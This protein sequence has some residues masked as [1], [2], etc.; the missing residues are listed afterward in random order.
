MTITPSFPSQNYVTKSTS[1]HLAAANKES[2]IV[3]F[4]LK[5]LQNFQGLA[6]GDGKLF[7]CG[8]DGSI[9]AWTVGKK[10][11]LE[12][13]AARDKAHKDRVSDII[14]KKVGQSLCKSGERIKA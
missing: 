8:A 2:L 10:G 13:L 4:L 6:Y 3:V 12:P 11:E 7:S 14:Y 5:Y 9:R 1:V